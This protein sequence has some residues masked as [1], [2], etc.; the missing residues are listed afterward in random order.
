MWGATPRP[1]PDPVSLDTTLSRNLRIAECADLQ[2]RC[3]FL[4][5]MNHPNYSLIGRV[6]NNPAFGIVQNQFL[7]ER[8]R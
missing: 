6:V 7:H 2:L 3:E 5:L 4:N 1:A 8:S